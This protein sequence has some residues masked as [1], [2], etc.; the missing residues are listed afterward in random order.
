[1]CVQCWPSV[2]AN[3]AAAFLTWRATRQSIRRIAVPFPRSGGWGGLQSLLRR[4]LARQRKTGNREKKEHEKTVCARS[5][6]FCQKTNKTYMHTSGEKG[7]LGP[8]VGRLLGT[9]TQ[10]ILAV[11]SCR[12]RNRRVRPR[13]EVSS[14][15]NISGGG[16]HLTQHC[17]LARRPS[18]AGAKKG[19]RPRR[20][21]CPPLLM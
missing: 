5:P 20:L 14:L 11:R 3:H 21:V 7:T 6:I 4:L 12:S 1:M 8:A 2:S 9:G 16:Q 17:Y 19:G 18:S 13:G 15:V 10:C